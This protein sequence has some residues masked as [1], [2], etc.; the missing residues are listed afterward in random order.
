MINQIKHTRFRELEKIKTLSFSKS[1]QQNFIT[2]CFYLFLKAQ[3]EIVSIKPRC[4]ILPVEGN[5]F[6]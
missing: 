2:S 3:K 5:H 1:T 4:V 6:R